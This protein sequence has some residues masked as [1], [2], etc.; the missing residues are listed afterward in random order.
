MTTAFNTSLMYIYLFQTC[1]H[2][3]KTNLRP[4]IYFFFHRNFDSFGLITGN[5]EEKKTSTLIKNELKNG[6]V[7]SV[8]F[9]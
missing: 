5:K 3:N 6:K 2:A 9:K 4:F 1:E 7:F 8:I